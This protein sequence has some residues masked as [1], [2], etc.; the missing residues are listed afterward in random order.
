MM[1][2]FKT[3]MERIKVIEQLKTSMCTPP[4]SEFSSL[5]LKYILVHSEA[6][7]YGNT[8]SNRPRGSNSNDSSPS[9][10]KPVSLRKRRPF[11]STDDSGSDS[12]MSPL[13]DSTAA[14]SNSLAKT[15]F[16]LSTESVF[17]LRACHRPR[18]RAAIAKAFAEH[19]RKKI[20]FAHFSDVSARLGSRELR[21][22]K[23]P[24]SYD[25]WRPPKRRK[26]NSEKI[27]FFLVSEISFSQFFLDFGRA[28]QF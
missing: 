14:R 12:P 20:D 17:T 26:N 9:S 4:A 2:V 13:P 11:E 28:R 15:V 23:I 18:D 3:G 22:V 7:G 6:E 10:D 24:A 21:T 25:A 5:P 27:R 16:N 19:P 1:H 8:R